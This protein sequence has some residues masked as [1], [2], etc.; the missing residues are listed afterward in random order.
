MDT[1]SGHTHS[2]TP[3][4]SGTTITCL[5]Q[6]YS[7]NASGGEIEPSSGHPAG[8]TVF[9]FLARTAANGLSPASTTPYLEFYDNATGS[10]ESKVAI[11]GYPQDPQGQNFDPTEP[12]AAPRVLATSPTSITLGFSIPSTQV[13]GDSSLELVNVDLQSGA[14]TGTDTSLFNTEVSGLTPIGD[15]IIDPQGSA[16]SCVLH[17]ISTATLS[18]QS[19]PAFHARSN[20]GAN[21]PDEI[22][23]LSVAADSGGTLITQPLSDGYASMEDDGNATGTDISLA[24]AQLVPQTIQIAGPRSTIGAAWGWTDLGTSNVPNA[25]LDTY[26]LG[27]WAHVFNLSQTQVSALSLQID[28]MADNALW[29]QTSDQRIVIDAT[30]GKTLAQKWTGTPLIGA[31]GWTTVDVPGADG[32]GAQQSM[33]LVRTSGPLYEATSS[34]PP[35]SS[36]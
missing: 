36:P 14:I 22:A 7:C 23:S 34:S 27:S 8:Q 3:G 4:I 13:G 11:H 26:A 12:Y 29:V 35:Q 28:A 15:Y 24:A 20:A 18:T 16:G 5:S 17:V 1:L 30:T 33:Y 6:D 2:L 31:P 19:S 9:A 10:P 21:C 32:S 25:G